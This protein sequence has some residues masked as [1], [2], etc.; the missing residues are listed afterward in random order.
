MIKKILVM[1]MILP[2]LLAAQAEKK[3]DKKIALA[4]T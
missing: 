3:Q 4:Y 1:V 2:A